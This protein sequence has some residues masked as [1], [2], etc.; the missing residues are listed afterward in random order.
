MIHDFLQDA[1]F[2]L[3]L[4]VLLSVKQNQVEPI[5]KELDND[6]RDLLMKYIYRYVNYSWPCQIL[7]QMSSVCLGDLR[8]LWMEARLNC[9]IG[10]T[11][12]STKPESGR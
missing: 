12:S 10:T 2:A 11:K 4:K 8:V 3:V 5:V 9:C 6:Q 7:F 1:A